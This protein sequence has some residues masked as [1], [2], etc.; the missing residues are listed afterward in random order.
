MYFLCTQLKNIRTTF[1]KVFRFYLFRRVE[2][3]ELVGYSNEFASEHEYNFLF[4]FFW[5]R[6]KYQR[7]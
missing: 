2:N 1:S 4:F 5:Q 3:S 7:T 6:N